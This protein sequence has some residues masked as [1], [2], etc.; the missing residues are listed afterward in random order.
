LFF[1][2]NIECTIW[3]MWGRTKRSIQAGRWASLDAYLDLV[4]PILAK[5]PTDWSQRFASTLLENLLSAQYGVDQIEAELGRLREQFHRWSDHEPDDQDVGPLLQR[6]GDSVELICQLA[7]EVFWDFPAVA[8]ADEAQEFISCMALCRYWE[9]YAGERAFRKIRIRLEEF[10]SATRDLLKGF[11]AHKLATSEF[12]REETEKLPPELLLDF[13]LARDLCSVEMEEAAAFFAGR[14]LERV[15]RGVARNLAVQVQ[16]KNKSVALHEM[17]FADIG[18]AFRRL[19]WKRSNQ[20][21]ID[22]E[23]KSLVDL[24]RVAR[25]ATAHPKSPNTQSALR[26]NWK[27][28][29]EL[30]AAAASDLWTTSSGGRRKL[31]A[32]TIAR[33]W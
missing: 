18:E 5:E 1:S 7:E 22:R 2:R 32:V 8:F 3:C 31:V 10:I 17:D 27:D 13:G 19:R 4:N 11:H 28:V 33:D 16:D 9:K 23:F 6:L 15:L 25:N 26:S 20:P 29:A 30:C 21:L 24:L 12:L 14:G